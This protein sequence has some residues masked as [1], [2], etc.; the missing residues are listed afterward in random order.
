[1]KPSKAVTTAIASKSMIDAR[2]NKDKQP[3][4][5]GTIKLVEADAKI[6]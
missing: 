5:G 3:H 6:K 1:V 2:I 4:Y